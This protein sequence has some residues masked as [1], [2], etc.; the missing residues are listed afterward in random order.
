MQAHQRIQVHI[1]S[2]VSAHAACTLSLHMDVGGP[3]RVM[4][5]EFTTAADNA[6]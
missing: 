3:G 6:R 1:N 2:R 5:I 4:R